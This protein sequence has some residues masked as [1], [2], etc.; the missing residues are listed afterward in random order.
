M[1]S[2]SITASR[3][4][5]A[6]AFALCGLACGESVD[7]DDSGVGAG[8]TTEAEGSSAGASVSGEIT[9]GSGEGSD[10]V[11]LVTPEAWARSEGDDPFVDEQPASVDCDAGWG[12]EDGVF[13]VNT[14]ACDYGVFVQGALASI[15]EGDVLELLLVHDAL[16]A[17][18]PAEAHMAIA[19]GS[20][21]VWSETRALPYAA[22]VLRPSWV[23]SAAQPVGAPVSF[24]VH[25]HGANSYRLVS[26]TRARP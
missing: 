15:E 3:W 24:H 11:S 6:A 17:D 20:Q 4:C 5:V 2:S 8:V 23:A 12:E 14:D 13:E 18:G 7:P 22:D 9:T 16:F 19:I 10:P 26:L 1:H 21:I 25:N